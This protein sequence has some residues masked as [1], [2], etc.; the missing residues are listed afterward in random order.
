[1]G[2]FLG[3]PRIAIDHFLKDHGVEIPYTWEDMERERAL[4][5][6]YADK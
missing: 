4:F 5:A 6:K 3:L 2:C 1:M